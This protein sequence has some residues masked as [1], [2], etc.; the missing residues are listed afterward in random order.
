MK[1]CLSICIAGLFF[2]GCASLT[3]TQ[4][5]AV[6][7]FA[8]TSENF[9]AY[10]SKIMEEL[11]DLRVQRGTIFAN[12]I[13]DPRLHIGELDSVYAFKVEDMRLSAK[14]DITFK[15]IDKYAQSLLLLSSDKYTTNLGTQAQAFG[16]NIDSL[17][18]LYNQMGSVQKVPGGIGA[19]VAQWITAGGRLYIRTRQARE[20]KKFVV[21]A[22]TLISVMTTNLTEYLNNTNL[23]D[24]IENEDRN[25]RSNYLSY[26]RQ[27][28]TVTDVRGRDTLR[29]V[30]D[31]RSSLDNDR[32]YI[33]MKTSVDAI[34]T[35]RDETVDATQKLR[36]A[37]RKLAETVGTKRTLRTSISEVQTLY[38]EIRKLKLHI[39]FLENLKQ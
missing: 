38:A 29:L 3:K 6:N 36:T 25:V 33:R 12:S 20:V 17:I 16:E 37:H 22:D 14:A 39:A 4:I 1:I 24:L 11:A 27:R 18:F 13:D 19:G 10:P 8:K 23:K 5:T 26:L 9:S 21:L 30:S 31:T 34:R 28:K 7:Q 32:E 2:C 35:L 15:I